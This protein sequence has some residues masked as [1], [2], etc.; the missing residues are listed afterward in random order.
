MHITWKTTFIF[1]CY[2]L[3]LI[4]HNVLE[5]MRIRNTC[6][7][8]GENEGSP[9]WNVLYSVFKMPNL[10]KHVMLKKMSIIL[11]FFSRFVLKT[12]KSRASKIMETW[13]TWILY[14]DW[15]KR[16]WKYVRDAFKMVEKVRQ[17]DSFSSSFGIL[18]SVLMLL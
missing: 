7:K 11:Y 5:K 3:G 18:N 8:F 16:K 1:G 10:L 15:N 14:W 13:I 9:K 12:S 2:G 4:W 6:W 17:L